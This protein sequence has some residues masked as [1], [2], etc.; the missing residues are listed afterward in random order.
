MSK[1]L[2]K[3]CPYLVTICYHSSTIYIYI[4]IYQI[5]QTPHREDDHF[6]NS[7]PRITRFE[8]RHRTLSLRRFLRTRITLTHDFPRLTNHHHHHPSHTIRV[9]FWKIKTLRHKNTKYN[10]FRGKPLIPHIIYTC[11]SLHHSHT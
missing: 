11:V 5:D 10:I 3:P 6:N 1:M 8:F 9:V 7:A 2:V 4:Y